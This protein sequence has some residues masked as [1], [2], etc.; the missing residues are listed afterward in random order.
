MSNIFLSLHRPFSENEI[1]WRVGM[2]NSEGTSALALAYVDSR[3]IMDR[4]DLAVGPWNWKD[5][6]RPIDKG[7]ICSL[8]LCLG[9]MWVSKEDASDYTDIEPIKGAISG[10]IKRAAVKFGVGRYLYG[11]PAIWAKAEKKGKTVILLP[12]GKAAANQ[13]LAEY[14]KTYYKLTPAL[15][16]EQKTKLEKNLAEAI[17]MPTPEDILGT[18]DLNVL[19]AKNLSAL[20]LAWGALN[21][22][23]QEVELFKVAHATWSKLPY[24]YSRFA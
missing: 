6:Y 21:P 13:K 11:L 5:A 19:A 22:F 2:A 9:G 3:A 23:Q 16:V 15:S 7:V 1:E 14:V 4:L 18:K 10:A 12:E 24:E 17:G 20:A 8:S